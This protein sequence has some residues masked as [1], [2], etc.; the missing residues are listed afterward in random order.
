[1]DDAIPPIANMKEI[2]LVTEGLLTLSAALTIIRTFAASQDDL[3]DSAL[4]KRSDGASRLANL[5]L[6][7]ATHIH[8]MVG[9]AVNTAHLDYTSSQVSARRQLISD[10]T[11]YLQLV[12][13]EV[14][15]EYF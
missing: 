6:M 13:K 9:T 10:L 11:H 1:M 4:L 7:Q 3:E 15:V 2:D 8:F 12:G 5:L 14:T